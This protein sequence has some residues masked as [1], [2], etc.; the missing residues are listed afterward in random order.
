MTNLLK[1]SPADLSQPLYQQIAG[2]IDANV[3]A[4]ELPPGEK[5]P[6]VRA[7]AQQLCVNRGSVALAYAHLTKAGLLQARVGQGT[8]VRPTTAAAVEMGE[9]NG[10][11]MWQ[12]FLAEAVV[13][14]GLGKPKS[15]DDGHGVTWVPERGESSEEEMRIPMGVPLADHRLSYDIIRSALRQVAD[16]LPKDALTYGHPQ[17][18]YALRSEIAR[19][20]CATGIQLDPR[21]ILICNG[22]QQALSLVSA[23]F[24]KPG[25]TV[26]MENPGY[27]GAVRAFRMSGARILGVPVDSNGM[28]VDVLERMLRDHRPKLIYTVPS[29]QV[30]TG[31]TMDEERRAHL[32]RL[33]ELHQ[34]PILEDEYANSLYYAKPPPLPVKA[35]DR[36]GLVV[37]IGTFSKTLG[38]SMRLGW[39]AAHPALIARLIQVREVRDIHTSLFSQLVVEKL[40]R[41]G[42]YEQHLESLR[43]HYGQSYQAL[44]G[45]L[46]KKLGKV[47]LYHPSG[48]GFSLWTAVPEGVSASNWLSHAKANGVQFE[49]GAPYF[50]DSAN[51][52]YARLS[53]SLLTVPEVRH[54]VD[55]L[56]NTLEKAMQEGGDRSSSGSLFVPFV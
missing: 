27:P 21:H 16:S 5:L 17:G 7:M 18:S 29:F 19:T 46:N 34:I 15:L 56:S 36:S 4:G 41:D 30:P 38:A 51:D 42:T 47:L 37:Y 28:R 20:A 22:T 23:L 43:Q 8:F 49:P 48:G 33:A 24:V 1:F 53:F 39:I 25:D 3:K 31:A 11:E 14:L 12:L 40:L 50:L 9:A 54:A 2:W 26:V 32:Y 44:L 10:E 13:R 35:L 45:A 55:V 6:S 52:N